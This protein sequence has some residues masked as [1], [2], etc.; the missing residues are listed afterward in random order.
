MNVSRR[1]CCSRLFFIAMAM[2]SALSLHAAAPIEI[3]AIKRAAPIDFDT[4]V[5][6]ILK[7]NCINCHNK[8]TS[9]GEL[10]LETPELIRKGGESG[11]GF[12]PGKGIDSLLVRCAAHLEDP[13][14]PP[15]DNKVNAIDLTPVQLGLIRTWIDQGANAS[16]RKER[17]VA[18]EP[19]P[20]AFNSIYATAISPDGEY[21][22][23]SRG[24]QIAIYHLPTRRLAA[25]LSDESLAASGLYKQTVPSH[26]DL[27]PSLA[28]S[29]DGKR[30]ASGSYREIKVWRRD[31]TV[32]TQ[33]LPADATRK[34]DIPATTLELDIPETTQHASGGKDGTLTLWD[35]AKKTKARDMKHGSE[36]NALAVGLNGTRAATSGLNNSVK[37]WDLATG[38]L[39]AEIKGERTANDASAAAARVA[40]FMQSET[41]FRQGEQKTAE[42]D[43]KKLEDR[44]K[45]VSTDLKT[46]ENGVAPKIKARDDAAKAKADFEKAMPPPVLTY[47][48]PDAAAMKVL[49]ETRIKQTDITKKLSDADADVVR[50]HEAVAHQQLELKLAN[51]HVARQTQAIADAKSAVASAEKN[52]KASEADAKKMNDAA[53]AQQKLVRALAFSPDGAQIATAA[54]DGLIHV[55]SALDGSGLRTLPG[56]GPTPT[57]QRVVRWDATGI[58]VTAE[59]GSRVDHAMKSVWKLERT[60]GG[61][62]SPLHD[63]VNALRF[64]PDGKSLAAGSGEFSRTGE[65]T[66]WNAETGELVKALPDLHK[67]SVLALGYSVDGG[68]LATGS[69]DKT[70]KI[71]DTK[72]WQ[73]TKTFEGHTHYVLSVAFRA[74]GRTLST[75]GAEGVVKVWDLASGDRRKNIEGW[76]GEVSSI[77]YVGLTGNFIASCGDKRVRLIADSGAE[78]RSFLECK[79]YMQAA[80]ASD[81]GSVILGGGQDGILRLWDGTTGKALA[82]FPPP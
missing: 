4:D 23:C 77:Q 46:A 51:E 40:I 48:V 36:I 59:D 39:I 19:V 14:M 34:G 45:T 80:A 2:T 28:F 21:G 75:A 17:L 30:L 70:S 29:P 56:C 16:A 1:R 53:A 47:D 42:A 25:R 26:R 76:E 6:P 63:R 3:A 7:A 37:L 11:K 43:L 31:D 61:N 24:G 32:D 82:Q 74:D 52:Q 71:L 54:D 65:V 57:A 12:T 20:D 78:V 8:T 64:S 27:V 55:W 68:L 10:N 50:A 41:A 38:V 35:A 66:I 44:V 33:R 73:V 13:H 60:I 49:N 5:Y 58:H 69:A 67:D 81:D 72:T 79:E 62:A 18:W 15:K 9:K 22:A